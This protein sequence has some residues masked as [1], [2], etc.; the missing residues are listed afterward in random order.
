MLN[1]PLN[2]LILENNLL[3]EQEHAFLLPIKAIKE[4]VRVPKINENNKNIKEEI[5]KETEGLLK[6]EEKTLSNFVDFSKV[7]VQKFDSVFV[8]SGNLILEKDKDKIKIQ[9]RDDK[10]LVKKIIDEKY[11]KGLKL[12][13]LAINLSELKTLPIIDYDKQQELKNYIDDLIFAL[14]FNIKLENLDLNKVAEIKIKCSENP[15]YKL[16][17]E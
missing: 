2:R 1:S 8:E 16:I 5:I 14:Y 3:Q 7:M 6:L 17:S 9:I 12:D 15:H 10:S 13:K 4:Y 11:N